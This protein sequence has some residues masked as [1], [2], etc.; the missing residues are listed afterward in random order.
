M[1]WYCPL[2]VQLQWRKKHF[3]GG[4]SMSPK[5]SASSPLWHHRS[6]YNEEAPPFCIITDPIWMKDLLLARIVDDVSREKGL[7]SEEARVKSKSRRRSCLVSS[8]WSYPDQRRLFSLP[9]SLHQPCKS[10]ANSLSLG[11]KH[12]A[13]W[14][15]SNSDT[16]VGQ[17]LQFVATTLLHLW[18]VPLAWKSE[19]GHTHIKIS[20]QGSF[21]LMNHRTQYLQNVFSNA[22]VC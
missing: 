10:R 17:G 11:L 8:P 7:S 4:H 13:H 2:S 22:T 19:E 9:I 14:E 15:F 16:D 12:S 20:P 5:K 1:F 21:S 3:I 18:G 6:Y